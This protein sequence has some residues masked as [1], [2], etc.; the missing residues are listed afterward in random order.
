[1]EV[2]P[3]S[4]SRHYETIVDVAAPAAALFNWLDDAERLTGHA[5][6]PFAMM[7]GA[8]MICELDAAKGCALGSVIRMRGRILGLRLAAE[9]AAT[10]REPPQR[11]TWKTL[12]EPMLLVIGAYN[13][14][15]KIA[16]RGPSASSVR[17]F[18]DYDLPK[19]R[20]GAAL[21]ALL[22]PLYARW[23]VGR[24][25]AD[26]RRFP[27]ETGSVSAGTARPAPR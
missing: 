21:G 22:A 24:I 10:V 13:V 8:R 11:K 5:E 6:K 26:A 12:G 17:V 20:A 3:V 2:R 4:F 15:F 7:L 27:K 25:A 23:R 19:S 1:M 14:G 16:A 18:I 9:E